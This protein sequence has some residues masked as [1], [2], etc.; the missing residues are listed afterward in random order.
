MNCSEARELLANYDELRKAKADVLPALD[1]HLKECSACREI[2]QQN[3]FIGEGIRALPPLSPSPVA[4]AKL[5][6]ALAAEHTRYIQRNASL[7][8]STPTPSFLKPYLKDLSADEKHLEPLTTFSSAETGPLPVVPMVRKRPRLARMSHASIVGIAAAV[9]ML[10]MVSGISSLVLMSQTGNNSASQP[11]IV[12]QVAVTSPTQISVAYKG[13]AQGP[14]SHVV[15]SIASRDTLYYTAYQ[16]SLNVTDPTDSSQFT[17]MLE[18]LDLSGNTNVEPIPLLEKDSTSKLYILESFNDW[19]IWL[20]VDPPKTTSG[21][22]STTNTTPANLLPHTWRVQALYLGND[23]EQNSKN[24]DKKETEG[25]QG[26]PTFKTPITLLKGTYDQSAVPAW[27]NSP[28]QGTS[29]YSNNLL[30]AWLDAQGTSHLNNYQLDPEKEPVST[31]LAKATD[32]HI[33]TTPTATSNGLSI[34]WGEEW[35]TEDNALHGN[36]WQNQ[37]KEAPPQ[38]GRWTPHNQ[39]FQ[40]LFRDDGGSFH[41]QVVNGTLFILST[42]PVDQEL[43]VKP[44]PTPTQGKGTAT[45]TP[46]RTPTHTKTTPTPSPSVPPTTTTSPAQ[47]PIIAKNDPASY[48]LQADA[49]ILGTL[50]GYQISDPGTPQQLGDEG[51]SMAP[52]GGDR[53]LIWQNK[54]KS[55]NMFDVLTNNAVNVKE[56]IPTNTIFLSV[57]GDTAVWITPPEQN[58]DT[59]TQSAD[60]VLFKTFNWP[61]KVAPPAHP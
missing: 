33:L 48:P 14:Y 55:I 22:N 12:N 57:K 56:A 34:Y 52:Q 58:G 59:N 3:S 25:T 43:I 61:T 53:F 35:T 26:H 18:K 30:V 37:Q 54:D 60:T 23:P 4:H 2:Q 16:N 50:L 47:A 45:A 27:V 36:I 20:Q 8:I 10:I 41:P 31:E 44:S 40:S 9:L 28:L 21:K 17:W 6:R 46:T 38:H 11:H 13:S 15:S 1:A 19:L 39:T 5:M 51:Q 32:G 7:D 24:K 49:R 42:L 29:T